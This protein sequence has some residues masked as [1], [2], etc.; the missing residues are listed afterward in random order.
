MKMFNL[1]GMVDPQELIKVA[2]YVNK[3]LS[4]K[5]HSVR[6][7]VLDVNKGRTRLPN[8]FHMLNF[9][10]ICLK[11][12]ICGTV[13]LPHQS[14]RTATI[15]SGCTL[16]ECE[17]TIQVTQLTSDYRVVYKQFAPLRLDQSTNIHPQ[18]YNTRVTCE[19]TGYIKNG[20]L[21]TNNLIE[22]KLYIN[23]V[24]QMVDEE[25]NLLVLDHDIVNE[26]YEYALKTRILENM[27]LAGEP[28]GPQYELMEGRRRKAR[29][30]SKTLV[31]MPDFKDLVNAWE[32]NRKA[33]YQKY[34]SM[35]TNVSYV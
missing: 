23:Y 1:E 5:I 29:I 10:I 35:F 2:Q 24:G 32:M 31:G 12:E 22:G 19:H 27:I 11:G 28:V 25:G 14:E 21:Y 3:D 13:E 6:Q 8:D 17:R 20:W 34:Y 33:Q 30:E 15:T 26:Y 7:V 16:E 9:A 4:V 18:C